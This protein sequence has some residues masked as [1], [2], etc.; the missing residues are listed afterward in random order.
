MELTLKSLTDRHY[1]IMH[2]MSSGRFT[3]TE[4][5]MKLG[6]S[7]EYIS[8]LKTSP[9]FKGELERIRSKMR[10]NLMSEATDRLYAETDASLVKLVELRDD[11]SASKALQA[12]AA[13]D[14]LDRN[15]AT[16]KWN[17]SSL[18]VT[19]DQSLTEDQIEL[20]TTTFQMDPIAQQALLQARQ[21]LRDADMEE[22]ALEELA[23]SASGLSEAHDDNMN[24]KSTD[25][26]SDIDPEF[27]IFDVS[28]DLGV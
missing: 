26:S 14:L 27:N 10:Q 28:D 15:P 7:R 20:L 16:A 19:N 25:D 2:L 12:K 18:A 6:V 22:D 11:P 8:Q 4:I 5:A 23:R 17:K 9:L 1:I 21:A 24:P 3:N 13:M